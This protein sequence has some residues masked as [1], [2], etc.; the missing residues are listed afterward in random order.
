MQGGKQETS[1]GMRNM[2][3]PDPATEKR[4]DS[5]DQVWVKLARIR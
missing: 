3:Y 2:E 5:R 4:M 1:Q